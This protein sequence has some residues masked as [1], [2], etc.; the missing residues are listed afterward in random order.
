MTLL[1]DGEIRLRGHRWISPFDPERIQPAS[2]DLAL[3]GRLL[4]PRDGLIDLRDPAGADYNDVTI[5]GT[6]GWL[7]Y[8]GNA[9]LAHTAE[10]ITLPPY[11]AARVEGRSTLGRLFVAVH[12]TA[13]WIDPGYDGHVTLEIVNSGPFTV[14]LYEGMPVAQINFTELARAAERPY[15]SAGRN[16]YQGSA[17]AVRPALGRGE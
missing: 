4:V 11:V 16:H 14:R 7:L 13:G 10:R 5:A 9:V 15:G 8:P 2:Y 1:S 17:G 6:P 3:G 12:V